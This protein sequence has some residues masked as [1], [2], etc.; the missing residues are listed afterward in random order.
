M[1]LIRQHLQLSD[2]RRE[3]LRGEVMVSGSIASWNQGVAETSLA[4]EPFLSQVHV[5]LLMPG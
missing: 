4:P 2:D 3:T 5:H 1:Y